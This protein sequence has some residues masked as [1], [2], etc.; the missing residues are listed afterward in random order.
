MARVS[1]LTSGKSRSTYVEF[2]SGRGIYSFNFNI[3]SSPK[4]YLQTGHD[5]I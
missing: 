1:V 2:G 3:F 5:T 4:R